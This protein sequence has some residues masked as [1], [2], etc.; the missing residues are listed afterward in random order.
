VSAAF[1]A[2]LDRL[3]PGERTAFLLREVFDHDYPESASPNRPAGS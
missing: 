3:G 1:V 2:L